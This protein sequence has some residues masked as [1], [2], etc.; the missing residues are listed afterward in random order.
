[1]RS[2]FDGKKSKKAVLSKLKKSK[3]TIL[4]QNITVQG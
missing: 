2:W 1:M 3:A 4:H